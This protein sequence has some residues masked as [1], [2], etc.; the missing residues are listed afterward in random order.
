MPEICEAV[1]AVVPK[2][3]DEKTKSF[4]SQYYKE[5]IERKL[6]EFNLTGFEKEK[7]LEYIKSKIKNRGVALGGMNGPLIIK[8]LERFFDANV[9]SILPKDKYE[10]DDDYN[11]TEVCYELEKILN[12]IKFCSHKDGLKSRIKWL[13]EVFNL[14]PDEKEY[15]TFTYMLINC[16]YIKDLFDSYT[17]K[18]YYFFFGELYPQKQTEVAK[19]ECSLIKKGV[20]LAPKSSIAGINPFYENL[21]KDTALTTKLKFK[22]HLMGKVQKTE[23]TLKDFDYIKQ[24]PLIVNILENASK[25]KKKGINILLTGI[26]GSGKTELAKRLSIE[27]GLNCYAV[28]TDN[29]EKEITRT[30]RLADLNTKQAILS[31]VPSS[32]LLF[33]EAEDIFNRGFNENGTSSKGYLN[34]LL[35]NNQVPVIYT[36]NNIWDVDSAF[37]RRFNYILETP[38][39]DKDKRFNLWNRITKKNRLKVSESKLKELSELYDIQPA[40]ISNA[41]ETTKLINGTDEM[42]GEIVESVATKVAKKDNVKNEKTFD[43]KDYDLSLCNTD[44][45]LQNLTEKIKTCGK[46]NFS[47]CLYAES[48]T[49]K[50]QYAKKLGHELG[51]EVVHKKVSDIIDCWVGSSERNLADAF[52]E[53]KDREAMLILDEADSFMQNR[54][55]AVRSYEVSL[56]NQFLTELE[57]ATFPVICTTNLKESLD[58]AILRRFTFKIKFSYMKPEQVK[59]AL[60]HFFNLESDF[61]IKGLTPGDCANVRKQTTFLNITDEKEIIKMLQEEVKGKL[62]KEL[63]NTIGF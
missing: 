17:N 37:L 9:S 39:L 48:G 18:N 53:C 20:F 4:F 26:C 34:R 11:Y 15:V 31:R 23:L 21:L 30:E 12:K 43:D 40:I 52:K 42:F 46:L 45:D 58:P 2:K 63:Q 62:D 33:D 35:E 51:L 61:F 10:F 36:T 13:S 44:V 6:R 8:I 3:M 25:Q 27:A 60:K 1:E 57:A 47:M 54:S 49:G 56:V 7:Y 50:S 59:K 41:V 38:S 19:V 14:S 5:Y 55:A 28:A 29:D 32:C 22:K 24:A 16:S